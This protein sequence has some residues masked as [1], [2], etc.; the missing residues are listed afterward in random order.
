M[1]RRENPTCH[2]Y[3]NNPLACPECV[4]RFWKWAQNHTQGRE[5]KRFKQPGTGFTK[6]D[7]IHGGE[8]GTALSFYESAALFNPVT[9][10]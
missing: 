2:H 3:C 8:G 5:H 6:A 7:S 1:S 4:R 9:F 10:I